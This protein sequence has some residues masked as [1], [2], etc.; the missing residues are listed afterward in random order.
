MQALAGRVDGAHAVAVP[1]LGWSRPPYADQPVICVI[2]SP[3]RFQK[4]SGTYSN[5]AVMVR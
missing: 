5:T 1:H 3:T 4:P 2:R